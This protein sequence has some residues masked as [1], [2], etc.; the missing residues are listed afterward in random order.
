VVAVVLGA[1]LSDRPG[2]GAT[3][4]AAFGLGNLLGSLAVTAFPLRGEPERLT[5]RFTVLVGA[6]FALCAVAP[7]YP[8]ALAAFAAAGAAN[9]PWFTA[10]LAARARYAPRRAR[11]Q[12]FVSLAGVKVAA[13]AG[14]TALAGAAIG[15]GPRAVL[16]AGAAIAVAAA[17]A[18]AVDRRLSAA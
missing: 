7:G 3:L 15:L 14:G 2:A 11:A 10:T 8:A 17:A 5:T 9:A 6:A 1:S 4:V 16:A 18:T 12:V 13:A